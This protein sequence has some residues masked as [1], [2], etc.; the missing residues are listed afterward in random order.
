MKVGTKHT[1][2]V[3]LIQKFVPRSHV[4][5]FR[6][7]RTYSTPLDPK[8][9]FWCIYSWEWIIIQNPT[10]DIQRHPIEITLA[11]SPIP[12]VSLQ[13]QILSNPTLCT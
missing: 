11:S 5:L 9:M 4:V 7:E 8:L 1:E 2:L 13:Y 12:E 6:N 10:D 3:R